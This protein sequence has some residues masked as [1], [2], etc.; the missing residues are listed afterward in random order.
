MMKQVKCKT[1]VRMLALMLGLFLSINAF[2][3]STIKGMVK[4]SSGEPIIS[5]SVLVTGTHEG[6]QTDIDGNFELN[7]APGT[8]LTISYIGYIKQQVAAKNG[9]V[10]VMQPEDAQQMQEVVASY[11]VHLL[12]DLCSL[13]RVSLREP[14]L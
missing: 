9:M 13:R 4:D 11:P 7:V 14:N 10:V 2:A 6:V 1:P 8:Q 12:R 5:A 3:Q